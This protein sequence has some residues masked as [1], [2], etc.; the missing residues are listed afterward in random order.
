LSA[1]FTNDSNFLVREVGRGSGV[2][3]RS[4]ARNFRSVVGGRKEVAIQLFTALYDWTHD[5]TRN[6]VL[7]VSTHRYLFCHYS[8]P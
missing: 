7:C 4:E 6:K 8:L 1:K 3:E 2:L 5:D